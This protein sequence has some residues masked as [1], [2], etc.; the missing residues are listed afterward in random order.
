MYGGIYLVSAGVKSMHVF[1]TLAYITD[2]IG[3]F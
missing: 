2:L 3:F 1:M